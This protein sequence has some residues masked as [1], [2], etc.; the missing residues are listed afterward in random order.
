MRLANLLLELLEIPMHKD[1]NRMAIIVLGN[2]QRELIHWLLSRFRDQFHQMEN[3]IDLP[4]FDLEGAM[5]R[6]W[7]QDYP[8]LS[9]QSGP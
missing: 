6:N 7:P 3:L 1:G 9:A 4:L 2:S 8:N 5:E